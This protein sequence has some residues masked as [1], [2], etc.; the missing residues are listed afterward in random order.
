MIECNP[1]ISHCIFHVSLSYCTS[2]LHCHPL[3]LANLKQRNLH[4]HPCHCSQNRQQVVLMHHEHWSQWPALCGYS[5][6]WQILTLRNQIYSITY[7][8]LHVEMMP[9][10]AWKRFQ[11]VPAKQQ[12]ELR[13]HQSCVLV[14]NNAV[15]ESPHNFNRYHHPVTQKNVAIAVSSL[16]WSEW[17]KINSVSVAA[18][19]TNTE[20]GVLVSYCWVSALSVSKEKCQGQQHCNSSNV[21]RK[22]H[23]DWCSLWWWIFQ[24]AH[25]LDDEIL[26]TCSKWKWST[27]SL[28]RGKQLSPEIHVK[29][30]MVS[31][32]LVVMY[33]EFRQRIQN[34]EF[35]GV[36]VA[37]ETVGHKPYDL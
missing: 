4:H 2:M 19:C 11:S 36:S 1:I 13:D 6:L 24:F 33:I 35:R 7:T 8:T 32:D 28:E 9:V 25:R 12:P 20:L 15:E 18:V 14:E 31:C 21:V 22:N 30:T 3:F 23:P 37:V 16:F 29:K 5:M 34:T 27:W 26:V 10:F 17:R